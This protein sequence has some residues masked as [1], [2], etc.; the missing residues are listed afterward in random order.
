MQTATVNAACSLTT[1]VLSVALVHL[2]TSC[3]LPRI[4]ICMASFTLELRLDTGCV[5]RKEFHKAMPV[6]GLEV[7][8]APLQPWA[9]PCVDACQA[10]SVVHRSAGAAPPTL[11]SFTLSSFSHS[12]LHGDSGCQTSR[13]AIVKSCAILLPHSMLHG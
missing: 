13:S 11:V 7:R 9:P 12:V 6:L 4:C 5:D 2:P 3:V 1:P 10:L 8:A